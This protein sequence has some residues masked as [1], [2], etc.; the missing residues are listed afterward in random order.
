MCRAKPISSFLFFFAVLL[1]IV[2]LAFSQQTLSKFDR[3]TVKQMLVDISSD[4]RNHYYDPKFHGIDW[5]AKVSEAKERIDKSQSM[6]EAFF[7][8]AVALDAFNDSHTFFVPPV[9]AY[10]HEYGW[11]A[12][13]VGDRCYIVRVRP[14]S[15]AEMKG[16]KPGDQLLAVNG[17]V[18]G[19]QNF[20]RMQYLFNILRPQPVLRIRISTPARVE[21]QIDVKAKMTPL[22]QVVNLT[23]QS[24]DIWNL[25]LEMQNESHRMRARDIEM[26]D[27][28]ILNL[29]HFLFSEAQVESMLAKVRGRKALILDLRGNRG[30]SVEILKRLLSGMFDKEIK[31]G[32]RVGRGFNQPMIAKAHAK[33]FTGRL[34]VLLDSRSASA[35]ELFARAIQLEK[36]GVVIG[37]RSSGSVM[38]SKRYSYKTGQNTLVYF[39]ASI[40]DADI[41]MSDGKSLEQFGV[42]P[43]EIALPTA[44]D[45]ARGR[46][47]VLARAA[48]V[49]GLKLNADEAG[50]IFPFEWPKN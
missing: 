31:V 14:Q 45:L 29:P 42:I 22:K 17:F 5:T 41:V 30:G 48:E 11:Q 49:L 2:P 50:K 10:R 34:V 27:V 16:V 23:G 3:E 18:P 43:D 8:V 4:I 21:R 13:M 24:T 38:E 9:W 32:D 44:E 20:E 19:R 37:D 26:E 12:Q 35:A 7:E 46:D 33:P 6:D 25:I 39:G 15:D 1:F 28:M 47:P 36:R 40:T